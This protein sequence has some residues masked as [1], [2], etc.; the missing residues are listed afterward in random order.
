MEYSLRG[1]GEDGC[2]LPILKEKGEVVRMEAV[3]VFGWR[4]R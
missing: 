2:L 3:D 4:D 1:A